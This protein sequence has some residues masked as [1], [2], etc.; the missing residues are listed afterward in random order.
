MLVRVVAALALA[1]PSFAFANLMT[2]DDAI[3]TG[4]SQAYVEDGISTS[5]RDLWVTPDNQS[6]HLDGAGT[7]DPSMDFTMGGGL[8]VADSVMIWASG[9]GYCPSSCEPGWSPM[10]YI[11]FSGFR[12]NALVATM[13]TYRPVA[14]E[15]ELF[16][17]T[18][19]GTIDLLRIQVRTSRELGLPG[20]C[21]LSAGCGHFNVD[22]VALQSVPEP[23]TILL[24][25][26]AALALLLRR[27]RS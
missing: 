25:L 15:W 16:D 3:E 21:N 20:W 22:N 19:L 23:E 2:F 26:P 14:S 24:M 11:W 7:G 8:F 12:E 6:A 9:S 18:F 1:C 10:D 4:L 27:R 5:I 13:G 17:L